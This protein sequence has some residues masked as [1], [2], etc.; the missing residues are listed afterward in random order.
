MRR[1][2]LEAFDLPSDHEFEQQG[3]KTDDYLSRLASRAGHRAG[4]DP[5]HKTY[6]QQTS[7]G[8]RQWVQG[9]I[10]A[11]LDERTDLIAEAIGE[12]TGNVEKDLR[13]EI[14]TLR[15]FAR[16]Y[17]LAMVQRER[18]MWRQEMSVEISTMLGEMLGIER[19]KWRR[20]IYDAVEWANKGEWAS[21]GNSL[22]GEVLPM[23]RR[24]DPRRCRMKPTGRSTTCCSPCRYRSASFLS[25]SASFMRSR[26]V[27]SL[28]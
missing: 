6:E 12:G 3:R 8:T 27:R 19:E 14:A 25:A 11:A 15:Q 26:R 1:D 16:D 22:K 20:D 5:V 9:E 28:C 17:V 13:R 7:L 21:K 4:S 23:I 24:G 18:R 10:R 2:I